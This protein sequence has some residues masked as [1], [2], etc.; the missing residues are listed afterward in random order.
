MGVDFHCSGVLF[1]WLYFP[2]L[3]MTCLM[4]GGYRPKRTVYEKKQ[5]VINNVSVKSA[6]GTKS[7][8]ERLVKV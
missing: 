3:D 4:I 1:R 7:Q 2:L 6:E 8:S 5:S